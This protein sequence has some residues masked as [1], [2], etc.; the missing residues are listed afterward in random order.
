[1]VAMVTLDLCVKFVNLP[2]AHDSCDLIH[3]MCVRK[4]CKQWCDNMQSV[5]GITHVVVNAYHFA[6]YKR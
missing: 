1:M 2:F 4:D 5:N 3:L 6:V